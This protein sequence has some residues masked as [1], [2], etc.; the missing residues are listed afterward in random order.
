MNECVLCCKYRLLL[1]FLASPISWE[2]SF[3]LSQK[4]HPHYLGM[5]MQP[6]KS[7]FAVASGMILF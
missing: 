7:L 3:H 2:K 6:Q 1:P 4:N 5:M